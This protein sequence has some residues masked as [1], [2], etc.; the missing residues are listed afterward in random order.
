MRAG[1]KLAGGGGSS[2]SS[3]RK[4]PVGMAAAAASSSSCEA[5]AEARER[6]LEEAVN[7][8][9]L[10]FYFHRAMQAF[11][12][13]RNRDFRQLRDV[14]YALLA[15]PLA[16]EKN[17]HLQLRILQLLSRLEEDWTIDAETELTPLECALG[18]LE[19]MKKELDID[20]NVIEK[21]R[22]SINEA[23]VIV[24]VKNK[25]FEQASKILKRHMS[26]DPS[27][28]KTRMLLQNIIR[29]KNF[30]HPTIWNFSYKAFQQRMLL[31]L[32]DYL[33]DAEPLLLK[34]AKE[35]LTDKPE[36]RLNPLG[37]ASE[38]MVITESAG[39]VAAAAA[40]ETAESR[41]GPTGPLAEH[42]PAKEDPEAAGERPP[43]LEG[44]R[45]AAARPDPVAGASQ[46]AAACEPER[47]AP[48]GEV[49]GPAAAAPSG[50]KPP[51]APMPAVTSKD[52]ERCPPQRPAF[53]GL[54]ALRE[55]FK[56]LSDSPDPDAAFSKL[57]ESDWACPKQASPSAPCRA[58]RQRK[59]ENVAPLAH[60]SC[61]KKCLVTISQLIMGP[62]G[63]CRWDLPARPVP[64]GKPALAAA[65]QPARPKVPDQPAPPKCP[66]LA[67]QRPTLSTRQ[68]EKDEWSD[69]DE[70]FVVDQDHWERRSPSTSI[71]NSRKKM[72]TT[73]ESEWI[74]AGVKRFGEGNWKAIF[75]NYPFKERT[76]V[77][78]KDRWR[79]MKRLGIQ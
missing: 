78:I 42:R 74:K 71:S 58:K 44:A 11:R 37:A 3:R 62:E 67:K 40:A 69:E 54:S 79:T 20:T 2:S 22:K 61:Q 34:M 26:K 16:V 64:S 55:A 68:E 21:I 19:K 73:E 5:A 33:E 72:W 46:E 29:E 13:G 50:E 38:E 32:E 14:I 48:A 30:C 8:W 36:T 17:I 9:A 15:R 27:S 75:R 12:A 60:P 18:L 53:H 43:S 45:E 31:F 56:A 52:S 35:N 6:V 10:V 25:E 57:D 77:M 65:T 24:C 47:A 7:G 39:K 59:E 49:A 4:P 70:L 23:A 51:V 76:P 41:V 1:R 63:E 66:R 28:Q